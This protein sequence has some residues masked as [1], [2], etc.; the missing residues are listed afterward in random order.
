MIF[1]FLL[2][3]LVFILGM[4][5][6][7][8]CTFLQIISISFCTLAFINGI[9]RGIILFFVISMLL[10]SILTPSFFFSVRS[11]VKFTAF[12]INLSSIPPTLILLP[13][14]ILFFFFFIIL[15]VLFF[16]SLFFAEPYT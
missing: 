16:F 5:F 3:L 12:W 15:I 11:F 10:T 14:T 9:Y 4:P 1:S 7:V 8:L 2:F 13:F 6:L